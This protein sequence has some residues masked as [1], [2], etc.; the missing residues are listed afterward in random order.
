MQEADSLCDDPILAMNSLRLRETTYL[1]QAPVSK[2]Q[3]EFTISWPPAFLTA[4]APRSPARASPTLLPAALAS[5]RALSPCRLPEP[6]RPFSPKGRCVGETH[7]LPVSPAP[8][9]CGE[10]FL[11]EVAGLCS[12]GLNPLLLVCGGDQPPFLL[13][14]SAS[15]H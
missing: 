11:Q 1:V 13:P 10:L 8:S 2:P 9:R 15:S 4:Q 12:S 3:A 7:T 6:P 5:L 14:H